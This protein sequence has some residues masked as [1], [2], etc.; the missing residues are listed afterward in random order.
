MVGPVRATLR[1]AAR[2]QIV[3]GIWPFWQYFGNF[4]INFG[5][6]WICKAAHRGNQP[7]PLR[8]LGQAQGSIK[9]LE[10]DFLPVLGAMFDFLPEIHHYQ[11]LVI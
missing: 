11:Q 5:V 4:F 1:A 3:P 8:A 10:I 2:T 6:K 9:F 7:G